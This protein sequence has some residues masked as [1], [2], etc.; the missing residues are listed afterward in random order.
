ME[1]VHSRQSPNPASRELLTY[2]GLLALLSPLIMAYVLFRAVRDGGREYLAQ[3][4][5]YRLPRG[6]AYKKTYPKTNYLSY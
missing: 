2:R 1:L 3:R 5:G 4:L 6:L